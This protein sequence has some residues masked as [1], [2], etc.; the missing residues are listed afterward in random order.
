MTKDQAHYLK[1]V[2]RLAAGDPLRI[3]NGSDGEWL[4]IIDELSKSGAT[5][6]LSHQLRPQN[7]DPDIWLIFAAVKKTATD[8]IAEK[9]TE[10]GVRQLMPVLTQRANAS[11]VNTDR[12]SATVR[13]AAQQSE[14]LSVPDVTACQNL[15]ALLQ[16]WPKDRRLF[17]MDETGKGRPFVDLLMESR[18]CVKDAILV[19]PEGGFT[20][21]ELDSLGK[22]PFVVRATLG[23]R[24]LRAETACLASMALWQNMLG[25]GK[26][27]PR[28]Q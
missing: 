7:Q 24:I 26:Q 12:I 25:D 22:C 1:N 14:R 18:Q 15:T 23:S 6:T 8:F 16:S 21:E 17:V 19:G 11:R 3:F 9:A 10:L 27:V 20:P 2:L 4:G 5:I 13:D 28:E